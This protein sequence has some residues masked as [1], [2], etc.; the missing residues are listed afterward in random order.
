MPAKRIIPCLDIKNGRTVKGVNFV[1]LID[2]GDP[3][4]LARTYAEQGADEI[5]FLD[6][7]ASEERRQTLPGLVE[8]LAKEVHVPITIGG[9]I[10]GLEDAQ[11]LLRAGADKVAVNS[12]AL[13]RQEL[14]SE[15]ASAL[16][17]Q[18]V[19]VAIDT[20]VVDGA[21]QV[22]S[23]GGK[24]PTGRSLEAWLMEVQDRG[25]GEI[26]LTSIDH[27]GTKGGFAVELYRSLQ[28]I[29]RVPFIASGGAGSMQDFEQVFLEGGAD[30]ALAAS[31]FHFGEIAIPDLKE[32]LKDKVEIRI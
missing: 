26:L 28:D 31:L 19:V 3:V 22:Y 16:G 6:I 30:A 4:A 7:S 17:E 20:K 5:V 29:I 25:A 32:V 14:I 27:D 2:A 18:C 10:N 15:L 12:G 9:G 13:R 8:A 21:N 1:N 24:R 11:T 23:I